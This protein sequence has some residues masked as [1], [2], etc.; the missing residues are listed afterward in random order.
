MMDVDN[1]DPEDIH[2]AHFMVMHT[3]DVVQ[4][5]EGVQFD[6]MGQAGRLGR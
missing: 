1:T 6:N 2:A 3:P 5:I 4:R